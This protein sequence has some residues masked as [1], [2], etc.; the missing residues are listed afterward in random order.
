MKIQP[1]PHDDW[2][3]I[4]AT[5][6]GQEIAKNH[7]EYPFAVPIPEKIW[8]ERAQWHFGGRYPG[9]LKDSQI[10][11]TPVVVE[12]HVEKIVVRGNKPSYDNELEFDI[13][14]PGEPFGPYYPSDRQKYRED[15]ILVLDP[16]DEEFEEGYCRECHEEIND[17]DDI[18]GN[19]GIDL[20][21]RE[22]PKVGDLF[23]KYGPDAEIVGHF[24]DRNVSVRVRYG[25]D[26]AGLDK[27]RAEI[28]AKYDAEVASSK[29]L[30]ALW[31]ELAAKVEAHTKAEAEAAERAK[32]A[33]LK[34]K[35]DGVLE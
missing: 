29:E 11:I 8:E 30:K 20:P 16:Y 26:K 13:N 28:K 3:H 32:L 35:Y 1:T 34:A 7:W 15:T 25:L 14:C 23:E 22:I 6:P 31:D 19:C 21:H 24:H 27:E 5:I 18:C 10:E 2:P 9:H 17:V 12:G 33:E 4:V